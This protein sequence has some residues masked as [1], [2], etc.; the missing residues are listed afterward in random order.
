MKNLIDKY[1]DYLRYEKNYSSHTEI[2]YLTD[3]T[4]LLDYIEQHFRDISSWEDVEQQ[5]LRNWISS[6]MAD[7]NSARTV[8]RKI[9]TLKAFFKY[10]QNKGVSKHNPAKG[11]RNPKTNKN[12]PTFVG[13]GDLNDVL[14]V[15]YSHSPD[16]FDFR[17]ALIVDMFFQTGMRRAELI[18][19]KNTDID[20]DNKTL[21]VTGKRNKQR[22]IPISDDLL[23]KIKKFIEN[24][25]KMG[26]NNCHSFFVK[27]D[28]EAL[29]PML[30]YRIVR[31]ILEQ[32]PRLS[33]MSPHVLRH[34]F[35]T[36]MLNAGADIN[37]VKEILGHSSLAATE[38]YTH[39]SLDELKKIYSK[40]HPRA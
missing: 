23:D 12:L 36:S 31:K 1:R 37:A 2:S 40:A 20:I 26:L 9:S 15:L 18:G 5:I 34:T 8:G 4:Q 25:R 28:G 6:L 17:N 32:I 24:K 7:A 10:Q 16:L 21:I 35:A 11:L 13:G 29:Y 39:A 27:E 22:I 3:L 19:L 33:K 38:I 30:V 14:D